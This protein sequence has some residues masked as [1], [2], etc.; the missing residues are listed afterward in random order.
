[1]THHACLHVITRHQKAYL[2]CNDERGGKSL[3]DFFFCVRLQSEWVKKADQVHF[4]LSS[5]ESSVL[6]FALPLD[7]RSG[8]A[9]SVLTRQRWLPVFVVGARP[10]LSAAENHCALPRPFQVNPSHPAAWPKVQHH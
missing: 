1:M 9:A 7:V 2:R 8:P 6:S 4:E 3:K 5:S 10:A